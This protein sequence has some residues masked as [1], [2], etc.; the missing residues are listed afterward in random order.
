MDRQQE[1][2]V[3]KIYCSSSFLMFRTIADK[4]K[5]FS[6]R[7]IPSLF[8]PNFE[9]YPV[10]SSDDIDNIIRRIISDKLRDRKVALML[11]SGI[12]SAILAKYLPKG[13]KA[14]TLRCV[15]ENALD[16]SQRAKQ[17]A[18]ECGLD[19]QII[20]VTWEDYLQ[21][22]PALM[23]HK[24][25][26]IHSIEPQIYKAALQA[27]ADGFDG[28]IFGESADCIFGGQSGLFSKNW[29]LEEFVN[30]YTYVMP[31]KVL[32][33]YEIILEPYEKYLEGNL[34]NITKFMGD[35]YYRESVGSYDNPCRL[36]NIEFIGPYTRMYLDA[37]LDLNR[38]KTGD[39]KYLVRELYKKLYPNIDSAPKIPMPRAVDQWLAGWSG[40]KRQEFANDCVDGLTGDQKWLIFSLE[41]FLNLLDKGGY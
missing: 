32:K 26:P 36:A 10:T 5:S 25:A 29:P 15:A 1:I 17:Y 22:S 6:E 14:Y 33:D 39:S 34:I 13:T 8:V 20:D 30:R 28:L 35:F 40:P 31:S 37:P 3:D 2:S 38:I 41:L 27:K 4:S 23:K 18:D 19:H 11:S 24:G 21:L 7:L 9:R 12:D 16:E